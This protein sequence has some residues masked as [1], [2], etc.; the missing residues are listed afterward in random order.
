MTTARPAE[1]RPCSSLARATRSLLSKKAR[2]PS[3]PTLRRGIQF[4]RR[5]S[6]IV[7]T[8]RGFHLEFVCA[9]KK[10]APESFYAP[11]KKRR[12]SSLYSANNRLFREQVHAAAVCLIEPTSPLDRISPLRARSWEPRTRR[13]VRTRLRLFLVGHVAAAKESKRK[14]ELTSEAS[15]GAAPPCLCVLPPCRFCADRLDRIS[16]HSLPP[17]NHS[18]Q[19]GLAS[20]SA[21]WKLGTVSSSLL[22]AC[23]PFRKSACESSTCAGA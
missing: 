13:R 16:A 10:E 5:G 6:A 22:D 21:N 23:A 18:S 8:A 19:Q 14:A 20:C 1:E 11:G 9:I 12:R 2:N 4:S 3:A 7:E 17:C 15:T